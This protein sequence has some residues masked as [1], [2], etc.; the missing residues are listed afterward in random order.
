MPPIF[1]DLEDNSGFFS[2]FFFLLLTYAHLRKMGLLL[3]IK[4]D[5]WKFLHE[6]GFDDYFVLD[7]RYIIKYN[8]Y[9]KDVGN[10]TDT[11]YFYHHSEVP[12]T[13]HT[14]NEY[15]LYSRELYH[16][17]PD[18]IDSFNLDVLPEKYN[19]IF[20]RGGDK[21]LSESTENDISLYVKLL[22]QKLDENSDV[23]RTEE[24]RK[25][26]ENVV[27]ASDNNCN[28]TNLFVH[29]DDNL[30]VEEVEKYI[31]D[32]NMDLKIFKITDQTSN[33]GTVTT[34]YYNYGNCKDI[35]CVDDMTNEQKKTH[36]L[37]MLKA[38]EIMRKS[39]NVICSFDTNVSRF[40][41]I[42]FDCNVCSINRSN[43]IN[44]DI[45]APNP[46]YNLCF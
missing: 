39:Q 5:K 8:D 32:N 38:I 26:A 10:I 31:K 43:D 15:K 6:K 46:A 36:T 11:L 25:D 19:S 35:L 28:T 42:N 37:L 21:L 22:L 23:R 9:L 1:F 24:F 7:N 4:D 41:K 13:S 30:L 33:G 27:E 17:K 14:L 20:I 29:S 16:I 34:K 44:F 2:T 12:G 18:I 40:M 45:P 3:C